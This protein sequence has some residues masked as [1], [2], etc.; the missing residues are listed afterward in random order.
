MVLGI[1]IFGMLF[2]LFMIYLTFLHAKRKEYTAKEYLVWMVVWILFILVSL[3]P[4]IL[5]IFV[6]QFKFSRTLDLLIIG[7]FLFLIAV[8]FRTYNIVRRNQNQTEEIVRR[9]ALEK[10]EK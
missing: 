4:N 8:T 3:F 2:G 10:K 9:I 6:I 1:Q 7:G 5:D